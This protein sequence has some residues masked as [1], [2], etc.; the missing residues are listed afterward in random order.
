MC[1]FTVTLLLDKLFA[2]LDEKI[3]RF[4]MCFIHHDDVSKA[5]KK[6]KQKSFY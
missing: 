3:C 1:V 5:K 6:Q 2:M 4:S